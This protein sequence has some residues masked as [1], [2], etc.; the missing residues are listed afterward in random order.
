MAA[1]RESAE[2]IGTLKKT[3][4]TQTAVPSI[5]SLRHLILSSLG[6]RGATPLAADLSVSDKLTGMVGQRLFELLEKGSYMK[7]G[8]ILD[9]YPSWKK[10]ILY[11]WTDIQVDETYL[12]EIKAVL[13]E[14][15]LKK[16]LHHVVWGE[17]EQAEGLLKLCPE[18]LLLSG[19]AKGPSAGPARTGTAYQIALKE[20]G[21]EMMEM[22]RPYYEKLEQGEEQRVAQLK[23]IAPN[24]I[25]EMPAFD[26]NNIVA[27][28]TAASQEEVD[29]ALRKEENNS[30][31]CQAFN[32]FREQF[33]ACSQAEIFFNPK[34][35]SKAL[36]V[37]D[38]QE[39][40]WSGNGNC[41]RCHLFLRQVYGF[42]QRYATE[43]Y[44]RALAQGVDYIVEN[45]EPLGPTFDFRSGGGSYYPLTTSLGFDTYCSG[46]G[47]LELTGPWFHEGAGGGFG[48]LCQAKNSSMRANFRDHR[49][50]VLSH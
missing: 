47:E 21:N 4:G 48:S 42:E 8:K 23:E 1:T 41:S 45:N 34:H 28:I 27:A 30:P 2:I 32:R 16:L 46:T 20:G 6:K 17:Q 39:K 43:S 18:L 11:E 22:M 29:A 49:F 37:Y 40:T 19:T 44:A 38:A 36:T 12:Q 50:R 3:E 31:L 15:M 14:A 5:K 25:P 24:G 10:F 13:Q 7:M 9:I 33:D 35:L 26:L